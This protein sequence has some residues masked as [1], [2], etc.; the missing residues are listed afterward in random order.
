MPLKEQTL[1]GSVDKVKK[2]V[3]RLRIFEPLEGYYLAFSGGKDSVAVKRLMDMA[4]VKYDAHYRVTTIDPPE[5]VHFI[6]T[7]HPD[8]HRDRPE[9][10][11]LARIPE[12][13]FP[14]RHAR[15]CCEEYKEVGGTDRVVVTGIRS[16]E[17]ANRSRRGLLE[18][19]LKNRRKRYL[20]PILDWTEE[21][22]WEFIQQ[23]K[24]P[25]CPLYDR[26]WTRVGCLFCP[27]ASAKHR[28][29]EMEEY[30]RYAES[31]RRAFRR[32]FA[33][34]PVSGGVWR[35]S[36]KDGDEMFDWWIS[37]RH[38]GSTQKEQLFIVER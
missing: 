22:V 7:A 38:G 3:E 25:Y 21:E 37:D 10:P 29:R 36:W 14:L 13:G 33:R 11:F 18:V 20:H 12:R 26:G 15:W 32:L 17:S 35:H 31:F 23:E 8:V 1:F 34:G 5:L 19:C 6:Q 28:K 16:A 30:P 2:S 4:G 24:L 9:K 27:M